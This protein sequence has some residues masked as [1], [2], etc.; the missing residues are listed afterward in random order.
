MGAAMVSR[1]AVPVTVGRGA[2]LNEPAEEDATVAIRVTG[3]L[4]AASLRVA[5]V[6]LATALSR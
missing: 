5:T 6:T 3:A 4:V 2:R 1:G